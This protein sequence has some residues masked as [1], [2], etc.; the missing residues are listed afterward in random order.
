[1]RDFLCLPG[2]AEFVPRLLEI[3][4]LNLVDLVIPTIDGELQPFADARGEFAAIGTRVMVS[5]PKIVALARDKL[6]TTFALDAGIPVPI[7]ASAEMLTSFPPYPRILKPRGG[8]S[9]KGIRVANDPISFE[10]MTLND[11]DV[12][13]NFA[14]GDEYTVNMFFDQ[15]GILKA[16]VPHL[17][18]ET[19]NGKFRKL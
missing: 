10:T 13:Q 17:R 15:W 7:T 8:S 18:L 9:S 1:M 14:A 3:S 11:D 4:K 2:Y 19:R 16:A 6:V 12:I 5:D